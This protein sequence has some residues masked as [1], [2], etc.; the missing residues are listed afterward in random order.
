MAIRK[1][2]ILACAVS[3]LPQLATA[4]T[5]ASPAGAEA[6]SG[7]E[8][9]EIIV[10]ARRREET[11]QDVPISVS[12]LSG[13]ALTQGGVTDALSFQSRVP[14]LS[15]TNQ[16]TTRSE[17]GFSIRGQRTQESQLLTDPPVG[18]YFAEVVQARSIG[19]ANT[20]YD[21]QSVQVL[22]GVQGTLFGRNMTG[23]AVLVEPARPTDQFAAEL[24][25]QIGNFDLRDVYAMVNVPVTDGI[26]LRFAGKMRERDGF[27]RDVSSGRDYDDQNYDSFRVSLALNPTETIESTTI[28][29]WVRTREHGTALVGTAADPAAPAI[30]GYG[31]LRGF[32]IPVSDVLGQFAQQAARPHYR[33]DTAAGEDGSLDAYGVK[34]F[35]H[36]KNYGITNRSSIEL[37]DVTIKNIAGYRRVKFN[38]IMDLDGV[39]AFLINSNRFRDIKQYSEELQ[40]QGKAFDGRLT[41]VVGAYYFLEKGT[42]GSTSSQFPEL[43]IAGQGLPLTTPAATFLNAYIG[44]GKAKTGAVYAA[45]TFNVTDRFKLSAGI[46]YTED[47]RRATVT[48]FYPNLGLCLFRLANGTVPSLAN[49]P[50]TNSKK[51]DDVTWDLTLQYEPS[52]ALTTYVS[53]RRGFRAGGFSLRA[54]SA[55]ELAPFNPETVQEYEIGLKNRSDLGGAT[56]SANLAIFYQD[57]KNVQKQASSIDAA[58]NVNTIITNTARQKHYGGELE[59]TLTSGPIDLTAFYSYVKVDISQGRQAGEFELVG[60]PHHQLGANLSYRLPLAD[61]V[62]AASLNANVAYRSRQ[63]LDKNDVLATEPGYALVNLRANLDDIAGTGLGAALFMNNVFD[64]YYRIGVIGIYNEAGYI[65]SVYG[66]PRTYGLELSYR[67]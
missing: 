51:W 9:G 59:V 11:L 67:F 33:F 30:A 39:P 4:Q 28:F 55:A 41:Y 8:A 14:S 13:K 66:E 29:D 52:D 12:A 2:F 6:V 48:S 3:L 61:S 53:T 50:Q 64:K 58:G 42:D 16:G 63:H 47:K 23:G 18:T 24:R 25:G 32:G 27:T 54:A 38:Q 31:A 60:A 7:N 37:G 1:R 26:A 49:C 15:L 22:K 40:A 5:A 36:L 65:S 34:P 20:L 46:R 62:G 19:F 21:L 10:T 45:G 57:Y 56:L 43:A 17:L 35:E 44:Q